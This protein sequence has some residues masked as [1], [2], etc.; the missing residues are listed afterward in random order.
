MPALSKRYYNYTGNPSTVSRDVPPGEY[1]WDTVVYQS[2]RPV[3]DAELNLTQEEAEYARLL[4]GNKTVSSGFLR[5]Q[6][7]RDSLQDY[8]YFPAPAPGDENKLGVFKQTAWVAGMPVVVEYTNTATPG[9]NVVQLPVPPQSTGVAATDIKRTDFVFLEVWRTL[10][11]P[12]PRAFTT[13]TVVNP[14]NPE[15]ITIQTIGGHSVTVLLED[16]GDPKTVLLDY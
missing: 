7:T 15:A 12:S 2:G 11:A 6:S 4:L 9:E 14:V 8:F 16:L 10:V 1:S 3:L 5:G 13:V